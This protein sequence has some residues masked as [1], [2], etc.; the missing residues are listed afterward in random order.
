MYSVCTLYKCIPSPRIGC[1]SAI[2]AHCRL[3]SV[4]LQILKGQW[5]GEWSPGMVTWIGKKDKGMQI[6]GLK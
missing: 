4:F 2:S 5:A 6:G 1:G 3:I